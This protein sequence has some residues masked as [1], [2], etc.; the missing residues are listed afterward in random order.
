MF[1]VKKKRILWM[2]IFLMTR[3][4]ILRVLG[5]LSRGVMVRSRNITKKGLILIISITIHY[6]RVHR[7][8]KLQKKRKL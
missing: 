2:M 3:V 7:N 6:K 1:L 4:M 8:K 5:V